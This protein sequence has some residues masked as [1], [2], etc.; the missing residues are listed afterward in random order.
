MVFKIRL[1]DNSLLNVSS[2]LSSVAERWSCIINWSANQ[3]P[4][5]RYSQE[6]NPQKNYYFVHINIIALLCLLFGIFVSNRFDEHID[7]K[8]CGS[9]N[10]LDKCVR[11]IFRKI[12][13]VITRKV[14]LNLR[15]LS[16]VVERW[17]RIFYYSNWWR[18]KTKGRE[19]N[20]LRRHCRFIGCYAIKF[21]DI[22]IFFT[23][24]LRSFRL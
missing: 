21:R 23:M 19:F 11:K 4:R 24:M 20:P 9:R 3:R 7:I 1:E 14:K 22:V 17:S 16:S 15:L 13:F 10:N 18:K 5:D 2:L 12:R 6:A 8:A